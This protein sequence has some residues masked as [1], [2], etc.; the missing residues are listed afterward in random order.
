M[1]NCRRCCI[2]NARPRAGF[3]AYKAK[4]LSLL[5]S[6]P[7]AVI[8]ASQSSVMFEILKSSDSQLS[9]WSEQ[10]IF[11][12]F[13]PLLMRGPCGAGGNICIIKNWQKK[14]NTLIRLGSGLVENE[15]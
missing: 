2:F 10:S 1:Y 11:E 12:I 5:G 8:A 9:H 14:G 7:G 13:E 3:A 15:M 4:C 6:S